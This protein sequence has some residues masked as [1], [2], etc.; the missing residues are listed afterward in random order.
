VREMLTI[1]IEHLTE[2]HEQ[3]EDINSEAGTGL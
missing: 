1:M 2:P 3:E